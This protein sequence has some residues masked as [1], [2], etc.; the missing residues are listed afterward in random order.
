MTGVS[1]GGRSRDAEILLAEEPIDRPGRDL[2]LELADRIGPL[3]L[4][5][6]GD[7]DRTR[8]A[9]ARSACARRPASRSSAAAHFWKLPANQ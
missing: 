6:A 8:R 1:S 2:R 9:Q 5:A 3:I 4:R 7:E